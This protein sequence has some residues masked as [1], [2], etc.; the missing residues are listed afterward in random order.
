M[1]ERRIRL[2]NQ[3]RDQAVEALNYMAEQKGVPLAQYNTSN[4]VWLEGKNLKLPHQVTKLAPKCYG[5]FKI[6]K[7]I[8]PVVY[9][10]QLPPTWTIHDVFHAS[11]LSP[12]SETPSHSPNFSWPPP[13]L[14]SGEEEYCYV[15]GPT[16]LFFFGLPPCYVMTITLSLVLTTFCLPRSWPIYKPRTVVLGL[17]YL[18]LILGPVS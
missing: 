17:D 2:M 3:R 5:P 18:C 8:S 1:V 10:L 11:L 14:I 12:Y 9:W 16:F 7:E 6:I 15:L 4:Q 13:D